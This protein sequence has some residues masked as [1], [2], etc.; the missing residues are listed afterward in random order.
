MFQFIPD[1][2]FKFRVTTIM[3]APRSVILPIGLLVI[4]PMGWYVV[5]EIEFSHMGK[6]SGNPDLVCKKFTLLAGQRLSILA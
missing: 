4:L 6:N 5:C 1:H 2:C 3:L